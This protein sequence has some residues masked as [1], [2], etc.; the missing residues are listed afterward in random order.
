M[1]MDPAVSPRIQRIQNFL[2]STSHMAA[3]SVTIMAC[4]LMFALI[5][6]VLETDYKYGWV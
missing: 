1:I 3:V 4:L 5:E 6:Y 2:F